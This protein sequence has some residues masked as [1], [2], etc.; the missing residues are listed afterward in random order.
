MKF[1]WLTSK[2]LEIRFDKSYDLCDST[3][4]FSHHYEDP[5]W[6]GKVFT[7]LE[8]DEHYEQT[9]GDAHSWKKRW[10]GSNLPDP[11][12]DR[13]KTGDFI[14]LNDF[15]TKL[16]EEIRDKIGPYYVVMTSEEGIYA[17][18][19]ELAHALWYTDPVYKA[20]ALSIIDKNRQFLNDAV[21]KLRQIGY[22]DKVMDD[23]LHVFCGIY[24]YHCFHSY[25]IK[26]PSDI[27][28]GLTAL[29]N[30]TKIELGIQ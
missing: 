8:L 30:K 17:R 20:S 1:N 16:V 7:R 14:G 11:V 15:E 18:D 12:F 25:G 27:R 6:M 24:Y 4:L 22:S 13:F 21:I 5:T 3:Y 10:A 26:V 23:E 9:T 19:H 29:F 2:I 28:A